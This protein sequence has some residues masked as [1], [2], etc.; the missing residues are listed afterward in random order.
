MVFSTT[1]NKNNDN[2]NNYL[3]KLIRSF[4]MSIHSRPFE[5]QKHLIENKS[6]S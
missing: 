3:F 4:F 2:I 5:K 6:F 1:Y